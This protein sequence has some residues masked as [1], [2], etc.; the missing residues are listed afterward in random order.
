MFP[1]LAIKQH[2]TRDLPFFLAKKVAWV[3]F[4]LQGLVLETALQQ[5]FSEALR[6]GDLDFLE[7]HSIRIS[8][9]DLNLSWYFSC[10]NQ[11]IKVHKQSQASTTIRGKLVEFIRLVAR[12]EDPDTLFFQR[13]LIIEGNTEVGLEMKNLLDS[14]DPDCLPLPIRKSIDLAVKV[15]I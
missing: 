6:D 9:D 13:R 5:V 14:L 11:R 8:I 3:P 2:I 4:R 7:N 10:Q 15:F 12:H 1:P